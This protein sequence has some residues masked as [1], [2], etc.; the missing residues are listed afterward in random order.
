MIKQSIWDEMR[1]IQSEMDNLFSRFFGQQ[2]LTT[3]LLPGSETSLVEKNFRQPLADVINK[4]NEIIARIEVP[5]IDKQNIQ[6]TTTEDGMEIKAE[7]KEEYKEE[8]KKGGRYR[9]ERNYAGFY[10]YFDLPQEADRDKIEA[11]CKNGILEI[12]IPKKQIK[13]KEVKKIEIK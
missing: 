1:R 6:I 12:R 11:T 7:R 8:D 4:E 2:S 9:F 10:R 5:G 13:K 3:G